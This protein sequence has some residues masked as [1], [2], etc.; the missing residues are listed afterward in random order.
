MSIDDST[1]VADLTSMGIEDEAP[2][3]SQAEVEELIEE[4]Y[5]ASQAY[6]ND[7][8][9]S[10]L[11]DEEFD[12][13]MDYL[14]TLSNSAIY[15]KMFEVG[16]KGNLLL[17]GDPSLG[18][19]VAS[20]DAVKHVIPMLSLAKAKKE[21]HLTSFLD[22][23]RDSGA[24]GF[25]LQAKL[26]GFA[27]AVEYERGNIKVI[28]TR[29][30]GEFGEDVTYLIHDKPVSIA[31]LPL[32]IADGTNIEVR[33][34]LFFT[35]TQFEK[36]D[37]ERFK[38]TGE[39]FKNSRNSA[40]GLLKK[41]KLGVD[42]PVE[43]TFSSYAVIRN[44]AHD[45]L[46]TLF[47]LNFLTVDEITA[48]AALEVKL[49]D[50]DTNAHVIKAV[51]E[52]GVARETFNFPTDGVVIKPMNESEMLSSMGYTS[53]HPASQVAW[54]Y[55]DEQAVTEVLAIDL[56][57]GKS[58]KVTPIARV[59]P[60]ELD[61]SII[62]NASLH[63][64]NL[65]Y[66]KNIRVGSVIKIEKANSIIPQ[67]ASVIS[68]PKDAELL[69]VPT[70][71]PSCA[72]ALSFEQKDG[73]YPPKTLRCEN[74]E[75]PSR[76]FF[77]LK[78]SVGKS[79]LDIDGLSEVSL[80]YL[81]TI[82]RIKDISDLYT[83]TEKELAD[84]KLGESKNGNP[85][86]MGESR[87]KHILDY[88]ERSKIRPLSKVLPAVS[89]DLLGPSTAKELEK[90]F[91]DIDGILAASEDE[92]ARLEGFG[93]IKAEKIF[94]GLRRREA[95]IADLRSKGVTFGVK[96]ASTVVDNDGDS[97]GVDL[98]GLSFAISGAVP[99]PFANRNAWVD[100][101]E[102]NGGSFDSSPKATTSFM[103]G[104][105]GESSSKVKKANTLGLEFLTS[106]EFTER[107]VSTSN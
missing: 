45:D 72:S 75:C 5:A 76:N 55:P 70:E 59:K 85:R 54:K 66:T 71:C 91:G 10:D 18:T 29:G 19:F 20:E 49:K 64:F 73:E 60:V 23:S 61:G 6:Y 24:T 100:F 16:S 102:A 99:A 58:G 25:K 27:L 26:D 84:S 41:A 43:F 35:N 36:A 86:R 38:L 46:S 7:G 95:L 88:I 47:G 98:S 30:D 74:V 89:I 80:E 4:L 34:E 105:K 90:A 103:V 94:R 13:K 63:N 97:T 40:S 107:F 1:V 52:F 51:E 79:Y 9:D 37:D 83:L 62:Q 12:S 81:F 14:D 56:T 101:V 65:I 17:E 78:S 31:G 21:E 33:G 67:V 15:E 48:E 22:K 3:I 11:S 106:V 2:K 69:P 104:D 57:V 28:S 92:I 82:G 96:D 8:V 32:Y 68:H 77:T 93:G 87:A 44:G 42:Y 50:L 39:R 53:H